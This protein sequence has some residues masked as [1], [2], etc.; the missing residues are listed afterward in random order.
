MN[1]NCTFNNYL[2][3]NVRATFFEILSA[4]ISLQQDVDYH[5]IL[6]VHVSSV[7]L[8]TNI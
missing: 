6:K 7:E 2:Y 8:Y 4:V 1:I 5:E 3:F